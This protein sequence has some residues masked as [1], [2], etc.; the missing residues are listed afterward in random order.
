MITRYRGPMTSPAAKSRTVSPE[1][2]E[3][4][5]AIETARRRWRAVRGSL[6]VRGDR[7]EAE[8]DPAGRAALQQ[9]IAAEQAYWERLAHER[10]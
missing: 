1:A 5:A 6:T 7:F 4:A 9:L 2:A 8:L 3:L 10:G